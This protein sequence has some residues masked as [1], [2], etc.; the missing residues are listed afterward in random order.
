MEKQKALKDRKT[1]NSQQPL[2]QVWITYLITLT[3]SLEK[4]P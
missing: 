1:V 4:S 2:L 3:I